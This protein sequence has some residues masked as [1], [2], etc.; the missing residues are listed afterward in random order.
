MGLKNEII[1]KA[2]TNKV[3]H[4]VFSR[5]ATY[6]IQFINSL[7]IA[8]Y[9]GPYYLGLWG[10]ITLV[11][12]YLNQLNLGI[13]HSVN[14][15]I[16]IHKNKE[17]Y[18][19]K[20][21]GTS[22]TMLAG[23]SVVVILF[24]VA[25]NVFHWDIGSKYNF[26]TYAPAVAAIGILAYFNTLFSN[27]FRVYG[28]V[29]EIAINQ[30]AFP[31]LMLI[32]ILFFRGENLLWALVGANLL[33]FIVSLA[34]YL[35]RKPIDFKPIYIS[36]L[37]KKIQIKGWHL[38]VYNTSFYLIVIST[39]TFISAYYAVEEFGYF[40][41]AFALANAFQL[42]LESFSF[43]IFPKLLN[44]L[45][46][47][48]NEKAMELIGTIRD[49]YITTSHLLIHFAIL[50]MPVLF[51]F[52]PEYSKEISTFNL[53]A[54][55][56]V[57]YSN[58][59]G[60]AGLLIAKGFEKALGKMSLFALVINLILAFVLTQIVKVDYQYVIMATMGAYLFFVGAITILARQKLNC[61]IKFK[62]VLVD[63]FPINLFI[64]Y[65]ISLLLT[66][67][68]NNATLFIIPL[69]VFAVL[70]YTRMAKTYTIAKNMILNPNSINI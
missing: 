6:F 23:L 9:L 22:L 41:F 1:K 62:N 3:L 56:I 70:N 19:Q 60:Y 2:L 4:Y 7:F 42:L 44:R 53:I 61:S 29:L 68:S 12:Q 14:A 57:L 69:L 10:F 8:V 30:S 55:T 50:I 24:F 51:K 65:L 46:S 40:T 66:V 26:S 45:S 13:S 58:S 36:R 54:L 39:R 31:I 37:V 25:N 67:Y 5:Y 27:I 17:W 21:I 49:A 59:F 34:I 28:K 20:V 16:S 48:T 52:F 43:L 63:S 18:V 64:P 11:I 38:F 35:I 15:I 32:T 33:S 47:A